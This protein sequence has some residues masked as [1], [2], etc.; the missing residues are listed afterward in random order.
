MK[1]GTYE[2]I[3]H[4]EADEISAKASNSHTKYSPVQLRPAPLHLRARLP[5]RP[6]LCPPLAACGTLPWQANYRPPGHRPPLPRDPEPPRSPPACL[7]AAVPWW[8]P[9]VGCC[10]NDLP[11]RPFS[12]RL[13]AGTMT[14]APTHPPTP[15]PPPVGSVFPRL[16][17]PSCRLPTACPDSGRCPAE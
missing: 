8:L 1:A 2:T 17:L 3:D 7:V 9:L 11:T 10:C 6:C 4:S 14:P 5:A 12:A 13:R 15:R 16:P